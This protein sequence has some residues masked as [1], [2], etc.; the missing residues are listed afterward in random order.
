M[1]IQFKDNLKRLRK[2]AGMTQ[3]ELSEKLG[4]ALSTVA[5]WETGCRHPDYRT[6]NKIAAFYGVSYDELLS[7]AENE[8]ENSGDDV[9]ELRDLLRSRP[10]MKMLFSVSKD[11]S[12]ED[13]ERAV[14]II[15]ALKTN[16]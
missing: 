3:K 6:L 1:E 14:A 16:D 4:V 11:A 2:N 12:K 13:I 10:E 5:M 8:A 15:E 9:S 7:G